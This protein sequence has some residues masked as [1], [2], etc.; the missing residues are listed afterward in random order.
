MCQHKMVYIEG[1]NIEAELELMKILNDMSKT[2][3]KKLAILISEQVF[4]RVSVMQMMNRFDKD[5]KGRNIP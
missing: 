3:L 2:E 1:H 5:E 4:S